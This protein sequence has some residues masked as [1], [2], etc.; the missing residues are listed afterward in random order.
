MV[1]THMLI[2]KS[3]AMGVHQH[4]KLAFVPSWQV[5]VFLE[6]HVHQDPSD[7]IHLSETG[8]LG[9]RFQLMAFRNSR[10][11]G[12]NA[13]NH[14]LVGGFIPSKNIRHLG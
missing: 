10:N 3:K 2:Q 11:V 9:R 13:K 4:P 12:K 7:A 14:R 1:F 5:L 6:A 8:T